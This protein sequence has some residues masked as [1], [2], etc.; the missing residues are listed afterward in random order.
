MRQR[1]AYKAHLG[2]ADIMERRL[3]IAGKIFSVIYAFAAAALLSVTGYFIWRGG[4][5]AKPV[6][7]IEGGAAL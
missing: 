1:E 2:E 7:V 3:Q 4:K 6:E 5:K